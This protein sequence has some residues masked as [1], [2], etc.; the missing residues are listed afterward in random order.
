MG[1][2]KRRLHKSSKQKTL[3]RI[4]ELQYNCIYM[5]IFIL[6]LSKTNRKPY[7]LTPRHFKIKQTWSSWRKAKEKSPQNCSWGKLSEHPIWDLALCL[8]QQLHAALFYDFQSFVIRHGGKWKPGLLYVL[9]I[10]WMKS[11]REHAAQDER[12]MPWV[13]PAGS[14]SRG[15]DWDSRWLNRTRNG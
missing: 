15:L 12:Y 6:F 7:A 5:H 2:H 3:T 11:Q 4:I 13:A 1:R 10:S 8:G 9:C 14:I